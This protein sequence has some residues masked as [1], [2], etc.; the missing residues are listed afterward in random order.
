MAD[1]GFSYNGLSFGEGT[2]IDVLAV[3]GLFSRE[4]QLNT[5]TL[6]RYHGGLIGASYHAPRTITFELGVEGTPGADFADKRLSV[7]AAFQPL[8]LTEEALVFQLPGESTKRIYCRPQSLASRVDIGSEFGL[9]NVTVQLVASDPAIYANALSNAQLEPYVS[10]AGLSYS[11]S[12]DKN[13]G[14]GGSGGGVQVENA[15]DW[16]TWPIF[17]VNGPSSGTLTNPVIENV[18]T[19]KEIALTANGGVSIVS[20]QQLVIETH[21]NSRRV[22]FSTGAGRYGRLSAAS[23]FFPLLPGTNELRFRASGTTTDATVDVSFRSAWI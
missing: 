3:E 13:Y 7:M 5:P 10:A 15:G 20:G 8:P 14:S 19:G 1:Y 4:V 12:Y 16:E 2:D 21:P 11:V 17:T 22:A 9:A 6:P 18:T 23:E